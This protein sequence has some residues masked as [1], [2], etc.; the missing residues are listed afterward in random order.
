MNTTLKIVGIILGI[1]LI[2]IALAHLPGFDALARH[3]HGG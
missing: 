1:I 2:V 3:L